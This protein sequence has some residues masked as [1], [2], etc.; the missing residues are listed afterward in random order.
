MT[1][2]P[3]NSQHT[4]PQHNYLQ[5]IYKIRPKQAKMY[6]LVAVL[7][8]VY[9]LALTFPFW[10]RFTSHDDFSIK[11]ISVLGILALSM[12]GIYF[13][14]KNKVNDLALI[15]DER[16]IRT[17]SGWLGLVPNLSPL[18][19]QPQLKAVQI[20]NFTQTLMGNSNTKFLTRFDRT[21][22]MYDKVIMV[23]DPRLGVKPRFAISNTIWQIE[24]LD[25]VKQLLA[26]YQ[27][28]VASH[29][30]NEDLRAYLPQMADMGKR[31]GQLAYAS[32]GLLVVGFGLL[33]FDKYATLDFG[34]LKAFLIG[35][36]VVITLAGGWWIVTDKAKN[37]GG[38]VVLMIFTPMAVFCLF[39]LILLI[40]PLFST[41]SQATFAFKESKKDH[42]VWVQT[43]NLEHEISCTEVN[44]PDKSNRTIPAIQSLSMNRIKLAKL[45]LPNKED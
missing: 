2:P 19:W 38:L 21:L 32:I 42:A 45:C 29:A 41:A 31:A 34:N 18:T 6:L 16:G 37:Y 11:L 9:L 36:G 7:S 30:T 1:F 20:D 28:P 26:Y 44:P 15:I 4:P 5:R 17:N 27:L 40:S 24:D 13:Y 8:P 14:A 35:C 10:L 39:A 33:F 25:E 3:A 12:L 43:D 22:A 23:I